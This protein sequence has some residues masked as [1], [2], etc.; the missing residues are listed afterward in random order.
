MNSKQ[1][2]S[3]NRF[4]ECL[5]SRKENDP[6]LSMNEGVKFASRFGYGFMEYFRASYIAWSEMSVDFPEI[7]SP[8]QFIFYNGISVGF[9][10]RLEKQG[11]A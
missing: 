8:E 10:Q 4:A 5:S 2:D 6:L 1:I 7:M 11:V 9:F 3:W